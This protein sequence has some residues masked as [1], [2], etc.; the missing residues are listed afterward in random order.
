VDGIRISAISTA[1]NADYAEMRD[2]IFN[3][4]NATEGTEVETQR[5]RDAKTQRRWN[6]TAFFG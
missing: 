1:E 6:E 3:M 2:W 4:I 5:A